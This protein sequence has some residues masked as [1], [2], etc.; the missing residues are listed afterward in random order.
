MEIIKHLFHEKQNETT[1]G[2]NENEFDKALINYI[3]RG[4][5]V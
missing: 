2:E 1:T 5:R 3:K 4:N